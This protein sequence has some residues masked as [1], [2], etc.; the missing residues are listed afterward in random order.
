MTNLFLNNNKLTYIP[1]YVYKNPNIAEFY[2]S[3]NEI[4]VLPA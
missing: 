1:K 3:Y 4:T 2:F